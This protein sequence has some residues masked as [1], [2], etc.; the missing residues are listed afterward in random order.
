MSASMDIEQRLAETLGRQLL[1]QLSS[2]ARADA[3]AQAGTDPTAAA[4]QILSRVSATTS[5]A[6]AL[7]HVGIAVEN[8]AAMRELFA[9]LFGLSTDEPEV[10]GL[11]RLQFVQAGD[12]TLELVEAVSDEAPVAKFIAKKGAGLHHV[13]FRVDDID[14]AMAA[15]KDK[16][17]QF[18]DQAPRQ[19]AHGSRIAFVHPS[20]GCGLLIEI[21]QPSR[22]GH[23]EGAHA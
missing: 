10:V 15:L 6:G 7:D 19:G 18:I 11:H 17:V 22:Y 21:K 14:R 20:S 13:C 2:S 1:A 5:A 16:G 9:T 23:G 12:T 8:A 3:I 4:A